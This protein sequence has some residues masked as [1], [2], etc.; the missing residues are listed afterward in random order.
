MDTQLPTE[1]IKQ[2]KALSL[3]DIVRQE[4]GSEGKQ[5]RDYDIYRCPLHD[6]KS[7]SFMVKDTYCVCF[8]CHPE[9]M[10]AIAFISEYRSFSF[11]QAVDYL[12]D[13][14]LSGSAPVVSN[15]PKRQRQQQAMSEPPSAEWQ[16]SARKVIEEAEALLW[17]PAGERALTYLRNRGLKDQTI[18]EARL[19]Y[20]PG[21]PKEWKELHGLNVPCGILIPWLACG[22]V[23][24]L[25]V[26]R[27]SGSPKYQQVA[28]G[29]IAGGL[30]LADFVEAGKPIIITE[31]EFDA[32]ICHQL[33]DE[34]FHAV[35]LGSASNTG[36]NLRWYT[37]LASTT[38]LY[39]LMDPDPAGATAIER[40]E[41]ISRSARLLFIPYPYK[42]ITDLYIHAGELEAERWLYGRVK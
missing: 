3:R 2:I 34:F 10:D 37:L 25:K 23:W 14:Y 12:A 24:G 21:S 26:R 28:G 40:L 29:N 22:A 17:S 9:P 42:D 32:L 41:Q 11:F 8:A 27:A 18:K 7:P 36:I 4:I 19:G 20:V 6:D 5:K 38:L 13:L 15:R 1:Q 35:A 16:Q 33:G 30:Y 39:L 31:G